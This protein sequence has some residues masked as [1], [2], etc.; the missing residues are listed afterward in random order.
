MVHDTV[1][2]LKAKKLFMSGNYNREVLSILAQCATKHHKVCDCN[3]SL[4]CETKYDNNL[5]D[6]K[7][8]LLQLH[9]RTIVV[10]KENEFQCGKNHES[11][12]AMNCFKEKKDR[13]LDQ[14]AVLSMDM[15]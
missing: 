15:V 8:M 4:K 2:T 13:C 10:D 9:Q 7:R 1:E 11:K 5:D 14:Q 3:C 12:K 6:K